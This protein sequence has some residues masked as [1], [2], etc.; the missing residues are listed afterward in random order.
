MNSWKSRRGRLVCFVC[1]MGVIAGPCRAAV[2]PV[3]A[4]APVVAAAE[5]E[6]KMSV[7]RGVARVYPCTGCSGGKLVRWIGFGGSLNMSV[8]MPRSGNYKLHIYYTNATTDRS[9]FVRIDFD[10][11]RKVVFTPTGTWRNVQLRIMPVT[12]T[13]GL[14]HI[15]FT[16]PN[17]WCPDIDRIVVTL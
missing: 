6:G 13:V 14:N 16:N 15:A 1:A 9:A 2:L 12:L 7:L 11:P 4:G 10:V 3:H 8:N 5:A 17:G